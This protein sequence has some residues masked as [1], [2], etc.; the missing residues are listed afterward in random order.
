MCAVELATKHRPLSATRWSWILV[1]CLLLIGACDR[2]A[3]GETQERSSV[4]DVG[5]EVLARM[6]EADAA[7][8]TVDKVI[9]KCVTCSLYMDGDAAYTAT[10]HGYEV[11]LCSESCLDRFQRD[12]DRAVRSMKPAQ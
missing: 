11:H 7:D 3:P 2:G 1:A 6:A 10:A 9:R 5:D 12:P 4:G 8:G